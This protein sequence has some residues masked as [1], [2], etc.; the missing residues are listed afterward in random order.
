[1]NENI[2]GFFMLIAFPLAWL[3]IA[4]KL[5]LKG[6]HWLIRH[7]VAALL[8]FFIGLCVFGAFTDLTT[9]IFLALFGGG[10]VYLFVRRWRAPSPEIPAP[11][12]VSEVVAI[13][14]PPVVSDVVGQANE[15]KE[16]G[17]ATPEIETI[18][19][20]SLAAMDR[21][22]K[23]REKEKKLEAVTAD[24]LARWKET[25]SQNTY[26]RKAA[27]PGKR[28]T[29]GA[30]LD[31]VNFDYINAEG[32]F[33]TRRIKV[34]MAGEWQFEGID[35]DIHAQRTFRYDRV[36]GVMTSEL[37]GEMM[38]PDEWA[39]SVRGESFSLAAAD[40][41]DD[42][43]ETNNIEI[44]FTGFSKADRVRLEELAE[45]LDMQVRQS[46]TKSLTHLCTGPNAGPKKLEQ[47]AE[48]GAEI[49]DEA[50]FYVLNTSG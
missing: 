29:H 3:W 14:S 34:T 2:A 30:R 17:P 9:A 16:A 22:T 49:I 24:P 47:A 19:R 21:A 38:R 23:A 15:P 27:A 46:V 28:I 7:L 32:E 50:D 48:V 6:W 10:V 13:D 26:P 5:K 37:T 39:V 1:M 45:L 41:T 20:E 8:A 25:V 11:L 4:R 43:A 18:R 44:C 31:V 40:D 12:A 33:S 42:D 35:L 36:V